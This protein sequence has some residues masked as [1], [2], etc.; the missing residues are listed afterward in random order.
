MLV[1]PAIEI[2]NGCSC[3]TIE[4]IESDVYSDDPS[5]LALLWRRENAKTIH[6]Y[7]HDGVY[8][9]SI[10]NR[11]TI[12]G[13]ATAAQVPAEL[14]A[15]FR[16]VDECADWLDSGIYRI[17][18]HDLIL[19][20]PSGVGDLVKRYGQ[21]RVCAGAITR[22]GRVSSTW[23]SI[24]EIPVEEFAQR[25]M[26]LGMCR[27]FFTDRDYE[28]VLNGPNLVVLRAL[29]NATSLRITA[30]GGIATIGHLLGIQELESSGVD[31]VVIGRA[32]Y[33]NRFPCQELWRDIEIKRKKE[34]SE[35][36]NGVSTARLVRDPE[37]RGSTRES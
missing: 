22:D 32:F 5:A 19:L 13:A 17:F 24:P 25:G 23:R 10:A 31:S 2:R 14:V 36:K 21:S 8:T 28:G 34:G 29:A 3:R 1:I 6:L 9:G 37:L 4:C 7:D 11:E 18:V 30:A 12:L 16:D 35:W 26:E 27:L 15:R 20:D 33:E